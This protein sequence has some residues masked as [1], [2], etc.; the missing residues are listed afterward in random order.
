MMAPI[1]D[2]GELHLSDEAK[3]MIARRERQVRRVVNLWTRLRLKQKLPPSVEA[4]NDAINK[5][6]DLLYGLDSLDGEH[7]DYLEKSLEAKLKE[8]AQ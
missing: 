4:L 1:F 6:W 2:F 5:K 8:Y 3:A 7:L